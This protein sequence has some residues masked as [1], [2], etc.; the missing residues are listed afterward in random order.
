MR[1]DNSCITQFSSSPEK[2]LLTSALAARDCGSSISLVLVHVSTQSKALG[3]GAPEVSKSV[4][5]F[6]VN[7]FEVAL[8]GNDSVI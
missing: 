4:L 5:R 1:T 8:E 3:V 2:V 6:L 7:F